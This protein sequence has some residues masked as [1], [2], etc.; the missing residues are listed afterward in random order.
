MFGI[1]NSHTH[2]LVLVVDVESDGASAALVQLHG[3]K[4]AEIVAAVR[5]ELPYESR[6]A[7]AQ[8]AGVRACIDEV[9]D[10]ILTMRPPDIRGKLVSAYAI[11]H[12]P[13]ADV[14]VILGDARN[15]S[16]VR[17]TDN[18]I[19]HIAQEAMKKESMD[20][21]AH[22]ESSIIRVELNGYP[23]SAPIDKRAKH[24]VLTILA[25]TCDIA[26]R[27]SV[28]Q[29][30]QRAHITRP[31]LLRSTVRGF[32]LGASCIPTSPPGD[33][34]IV[35]ISRAGSRV[36]HITDGL[37]TTLTTIEHG[38]NSL[39][40]HIAPNKHPADILALMRLVEA[41]E[42]TEEACT[43]FLQNLGRAESQLSEIY[44]QAFTS[45]AKQG[46]L[47]QSLILIVHP[48]LAPWLSR[49]FTRPEF[50]PCVTTHK[51][52]SV[53]ILDATHFTQS[54]QVREHVDVSLGLISATALVYSEPTR[55]TA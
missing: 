22:I 43:S 36:I 4:P 26:I 16:D 28:L 51:P 41:G 23:T 27:E 15:K 9:T 12:M 53:Q 54:V 17:V 10:K 18:L 6:S 55:R 13:W 3:S 33:H 20:P 52:F 30:V 31:P 34:T 47:P 32:A 21:A 45:I 11:V 46:L 48:T 7:D 44:T 5:T 49:F 25:S 2:D 29:A 42:C 1:G 24:I 19:S 40:T 37:P 39:F 38:L 8:I 50:S 14:R 35:D